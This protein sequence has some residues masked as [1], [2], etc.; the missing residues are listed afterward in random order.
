VHTI[1]I[2]AVANDTAEPRLGPLAQSKIRAGFDRDGSL[3]VLDDEGAADSVLHA[4]V[5]DYEYRSKGQVRNAS[6]D[7]DQEVYVSVIYAVRVTIRYQVTRPGHA[8]P[9]VG[10]RTAVGEAE[11]AELPDLEVAR[12]DAWRIALA[13]AAEGVVSGVTEAW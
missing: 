7:N 10:W 4:T 1:A 8:K 5:T 13:D 11:F 6:S 12:A 9:L 2:P 3:R